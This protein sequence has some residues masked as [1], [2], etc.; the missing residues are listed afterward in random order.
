M[1]ENHHSEPVRGRPVRACR[2]HEPLI[3]PEN[4]IFY[5]Q[6]PSQPRI[7]VRAQ[8]P[9]RPSD[10]RQISLLDKLLGISAD[11]DFEK[12][13]DVLCAGRQ[14]CTYRIQATR[15]CMSSTIRRRRSHLARPERRRRLSACR[16]RVR[17]LPDGTIFVVDPAAAEGPR[18]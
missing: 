1:K 13:L 4:P 18:L 11:Q 15:S 2:L 9:G 17:G 12:P 6:A 10:F 5:P 3:K 16:W 7:N 14:G 8:H